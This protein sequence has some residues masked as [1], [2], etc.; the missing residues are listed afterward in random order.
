MNRSG[1]L[2]KEAIKQLLKLLLS[3]TIL[4]K[5][6]PALQ[7]QSDFAKPYQ[8]MYDNAINV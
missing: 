8:K 7:Y 5:R 2:Y 1:E 3:K 6:W 4:K